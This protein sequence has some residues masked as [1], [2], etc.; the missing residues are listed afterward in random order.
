MPQSYFKLGEKKTFLGILA[1]LGDFGIFPLIF[2]DFLTIS[3]VER[4]DI[5]QRVLHGVHFFFQE[6]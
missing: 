5:Q 3:I 1:F 6:N 2:S 4:R